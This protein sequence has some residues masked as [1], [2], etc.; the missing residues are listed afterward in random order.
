MTPECLGPNLCRAA[1]GPG[2]RQLLRLRSDRSS[3]SDP[4][5]A[6]G[7]QEGPG[8]SS[9]WAGGAGAHN[10]GGGG[11]GDLGLRP[12]GDSGELAATLQLQRGLRLRE[13]RLRPQPGQPFD[14][15]SCPS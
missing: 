10:G 1:R 14:T 4:D 12:Y 6:G 11:G 7:S 5:I 13:V 8:G 3:A 9:G 2:E 15:V